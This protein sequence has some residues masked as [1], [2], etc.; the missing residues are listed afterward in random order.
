MTTHAWMK[1]DVTYVND[2]RADNHDYDENTDDDDNNI[3]DVYGHT[4]IKIYSYLDV[5]AMLYP[6]YKVF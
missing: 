3:N 6:C 5:I 1:F 2:E 4:A